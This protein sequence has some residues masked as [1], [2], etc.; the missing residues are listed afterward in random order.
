MAEQHE[1]RIIVH[2][3]EDARAALGVAAE[4]GLPV[5]LES[6]AGAAGYGGPLWFLALVERARQDHPAA[7]VA[8]VLDCGEEAGTALGALRAG[9]KRVRFAGPASV[10]ARLQA[11]AAELGA[12][13]EG[14]AAGE[15]LDLLDQADP[16]GAV[17]RFLA[18]N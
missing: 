3:L 16:R 17:R 5:T 6:G 8:S 15:R 9:A 18:G 14:P 13:I 7:E 1:H 11:I 12:A 4:L 10:A 2:S